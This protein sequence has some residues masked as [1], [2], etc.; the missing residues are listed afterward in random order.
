LFGFDSTDFF[1]LTFQTLR[2]KSLFFGGIMRKSKMKR[3]DRFGGVPESEIIVPP[4]LREPEEDPNPMGF[5]ERDKSRL[6]KRRVKAQ[7]RDR[8]G[9]VPN[10]MIVEPP[11]TMSEGEVAE[12]ADRVEEEVMNS[13][14]NRRRYTQRDHVRNDVML[15]HEHP[16]SDQ[17][18]QRRGPGQP[19]FEQGSDVELTPDVVDQVGQMM[20]DRS[21]DVF[22]SSDVPG[23][24][25]NAD[26][27]LPK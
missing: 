12:Q 15:R 19:V 5:S 25:P 16:Q 21:V 20:E 6:E 27:A 2:D 11:K 9:A 17:F 7:S 10:D 14:M 1:L 18:G 4:R 26:D 13:A 3:Y 23:H 22:T 24:I 8:F